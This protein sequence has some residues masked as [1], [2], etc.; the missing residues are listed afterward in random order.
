MKNIFQVTVS[1]RYSRNPNSLYRYSRWLP[2]NLTALILCEHGT[3]LI[4]L[5]SAHLR[6]S[7]HHRVTHKKYT[8]A[9]TP[10]PSKHHHKYQLHKSLVLDLMLIFFFC[11]LN[12]TK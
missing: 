6:S 1:F 11:I 7:G 3:V 2:F 8:D 9:Y 4:S 12:Y 10:L 5:D